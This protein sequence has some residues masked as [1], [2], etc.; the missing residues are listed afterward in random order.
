MDSLASFFMTRERF[1]AFLS[2]L[3]AVKVELFVG[4]HPSQVDA[5][6]NK[7]FSKE[8][9]DAITAKLTTSAKNMSDVHEVD[10]GI[11]TLLNELSNY[12]FL[13]LSTAIDL[14]ESFI[15]EL[16]MWVYENVGHDVI[17]DLR[18]KP[19]ILGGIELSYEGKYVDLTIKSKLEKVK[20]TI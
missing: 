3:E 10:S 7:C 14:S 20:V 13:K 19:Y 1:E 5:V 4:N 8:I 16:F 9:T 6:L 12:K 18:T 11:T 15:K 2:Q 17:L